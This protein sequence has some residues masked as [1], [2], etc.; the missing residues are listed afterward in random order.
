MPTMCRTLG[1][2]NRRDSVVRLYLP[3]RSGLPLQNT[4]SSQSTMDSMSSD[5]VGFP[6][7]LR[8]NL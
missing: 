5:V 6:S 8:I 7:I 4:P 2:P 1:A 3:F